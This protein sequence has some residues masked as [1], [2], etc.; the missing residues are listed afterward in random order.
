MQVEALMQKR[1][2]WALEENSLPEAM[3]QWRWMRLNPACNDFGWLHP[4]PPSL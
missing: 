1:A 3:K 4:T 2:L